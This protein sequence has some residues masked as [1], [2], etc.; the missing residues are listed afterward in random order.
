MLIY[1][2]VAIKFFQLIFLKYKKPLSVAERVE[3]KYK[4]SHNELFEG[5]SEKEAKLMEMTI[6][7]T[8]KNT[9]IAPSKS[10]L[11]KKGKRKQVSF[12]E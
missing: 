6:N 10:K 3:K 9:Q 7:N 5:Y 11:V 2:L 1:C 4:Y 8:I 12:K